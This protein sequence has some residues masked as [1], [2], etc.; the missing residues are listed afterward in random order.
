VEGIQLR[1]YKDNQKDLRKALKYH[2]HGQRQS[3]AKVNAPMKKLQSQHTDIIKIRTIHKQSRMQTTEELLNPLNEMLL[4]HVNVS[5]YSATGK[6]MQIVYFM[7]RHNIALM[8]SSE[9]L[10]MI[11][12]VCGHKIANRHRER[13]SALRM[14]N[15]ISRQFHRNLMVHLTARYKG[16]LSLSLDG[17]TDR[18]NKHHILVYIRAIENGHPVDYYYKDIELKTDQSGAS[19]LNALTAEFERDSNDFERRY[20]ITKAIHERLV[21]FGSDGGLQLIHIF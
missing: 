3:S 2:L 21:G 6:M 10:K 1:K 16:P 19:H 15:S 14:L 12:S 4:P 8:K 11:E 5:T 13:T 17:S 18:V 7:A 20:N 9:T